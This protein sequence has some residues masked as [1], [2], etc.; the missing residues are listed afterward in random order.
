MTSQ[1]R[2]AAILN[3]YFDQLAQRAG[4][5]WTERNRA[6]IARA[7]QLLGQT[8]EDQADT[9]PPYQPTDQ[10]ER[11]RVTQVIERDPL[12]EDLRFQRWRQERTASQEHDTRRILRQSGAN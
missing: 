4:V 2:A 8:D 3:H 5:R 11:E 10:A 1:E 9:I 6:D 12:E 7:S